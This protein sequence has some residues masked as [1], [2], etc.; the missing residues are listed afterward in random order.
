MRHC[1]CFFMI[2]HGSWFQF[3]ARL[4][5]HL[6]NIVSLIIL[7]LLSYRGISD[8]LNVFAIIFYRFAAADIH[9]QGLKQRAISERN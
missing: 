1:V 9:I 3:P 4:S 2:R 5:I 8:N 7:F 6:I